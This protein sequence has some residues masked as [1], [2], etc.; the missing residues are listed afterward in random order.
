MWPM[1]PK[2]WLS[3]HS[4]SINLNINSHLW[5]APTKL[6]STVRKGQPQ[7]GREVQLGVGSLSV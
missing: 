7:D 2:N 5:L 1:P 4:I 6:G 3:F